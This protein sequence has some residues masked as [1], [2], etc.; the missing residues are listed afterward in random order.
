[1]SR[2]STRTGRH[3]L[4]VLGAAVAL[5]LA[6]LVGPP[7]GAAG[8]GSAEASLN[9]YSAS[10]TAEQAGELARSGHDMSS[11]KGTADGVTADL[12]LTSQEASALR[13]RGMSVKL[14]RLKDGKT[15]QEFAA[16]Q[17]ANGFT[18][19]RS[20]DEAGGIRDQLYAAARKNPQ[21]VKLEVLG[22]T[23]QGRE[24]IAVKLTQGA[25]EVPD[26]SR[27]AVLYSSTQHAR[28][29]I[30]TEVNRRLMTHFIDRWRPNDR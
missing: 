9:V 11:A 23:A 10:L 8:R 2:R 25:Q 17:A 13:D 22:H 20:Y 29:W 5:V 15:V 14:K 12:V 3:I 30:S 4:V 26:G 7:A 28:E 6:T 19:W 1:M 21:L 18:V 27:A 24:L 16:A